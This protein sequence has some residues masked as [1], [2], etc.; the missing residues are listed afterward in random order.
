MELSDVTSGMS[1][2]SKGLRIARK[3]FIAMLILIASLGYYD[4]KSDREVF[5]A[6]LTAVENQTAI[7]STS[8]QA[9]GAME[10]VRLSNIETNIS[11]ISTTQ[12]RMRTEFRESQAELQRQILNML[13]TRRGITP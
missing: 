7:I 8:T 6:R 2:S 11:N 5:H 4:F 12:E 9:S 10:S 3:A 1:W 13:T